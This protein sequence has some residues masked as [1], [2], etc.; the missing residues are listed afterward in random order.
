MDDLTVI[1]VN[2]LQK[3]SGTDEGEAEVCR[4]EDAREGRLHIGD[5]KSILRSAVGM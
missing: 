1:D 5:D 4:R 3:T 2:G